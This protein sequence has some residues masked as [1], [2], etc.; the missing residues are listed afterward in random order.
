MNNVIELLKDVV[1]ALQKFIAAV[2]FEQAAVEEPVVEQ[3]IVEPIVVEPIV[4]EPIVE[5]PVIEPIVEEPIVEEPVVEPIIEPVEE[6][7]EEPIEEPAID[8]PISEPVEESG[9]EVIEVV[10]ELVEF[11]EQEPIVEVAVVD[12]PQNI[13]VIVGEVLEGKW[14]SGTKRKQNLEAA[15][16][17]YDKVQ[18]RVNE[19]LTVVDEVLDGKWGNGEVRQQRLTDAGYNYKVIQDRINVVLASKINIQ[20]EICAWAKKIADSKKYKYKT[21]KSN[22]VKT[23]QCPLCHPGSGD[24]W[25]CIG[26]AFAC[27]HHGGNIPSKCNCGVIANDTWEKI[28][29]AK[30]DQEALQLAQKYIGIKEVQVIRNKGNAIPTDRLRKGDIIAYYVNGDNYQ[31]TALYIGNNLMADSSAGNSGKYITYGKK[32]RSG[33]NVAI[34][35]TGD[36]KGKT[37]DTLAKEVLN[38]QWGSGDIRKLNLVAAGCDYDKVQA[39]V[40]ELLKENP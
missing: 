11:I 3:P 30:T 33:L 29:K 16:Y 28:L 6:L 7:V 8:T 39:R 13:D 26:F 19:I 4:E 27:W 5:E 1:V 20:D 37:I 22:D 17:D 2:E 21:W 15:G 31:H 18:Q 23:H 34:R 35:W 32:L 36:A 12:D 25:N 10:D 38:G 14:G 9:G 24:G 40:N